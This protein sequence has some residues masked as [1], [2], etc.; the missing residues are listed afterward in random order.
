M[1]DAHGNG[2]R[3]RLVSAAEAGSLDWQNDVGGI[4]FA[5]VCEDV[6]STNAKSP[7][8]SKVTAV[9]ETLETG[10]AYGWTLM[11]FDPTYSANESP[12]VMGEATTAEEAKRQAEDA[13]RKVAACLKAIRG[14]G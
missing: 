8:T 13:G 2:G 11:V 10:R 5:E 3:R 7:R 12:L 4:V 9:V 6:A 1:R 14:E